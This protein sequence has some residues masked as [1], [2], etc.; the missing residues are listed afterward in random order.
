[1]KNKRKKFWEVKNAANDTGELYI[2]GDIVSYQWDDSDTTAQSFNDDLKALGDI[3]TLNVYLN[4]PGG[5]VFQGQAIHTILKRHKARVNVHVDGVAASIASVIA[6]AGDAV[7]MPKNAM[8]M[9]HNPWTYAAGN[10][11]DLRKA[12]DD[13]DK[14]AESIVEAYLGKTGDSLSREQL[15]EIMDSETWLT[16]DEC[17]AYGLC[18]VVTEAKEIAASADPEWFAR[19]KNTP[20]TLVKA[21]EQ[22][23]DAGTI[24]EEERQQL[25]A[26][27]KE[28]IK[29]INSILGV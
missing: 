21:V 5:S 17:L 18:D 2:Y 4:S 15:T 10:A 24:S 26:A 7:Y 1:M 28:N 16:A 23:H 22:K 29:S 19:F 25:I 8:M 27:A 11:N 9:I 12:A 13:L 6:M 14:I 3:K 20:D